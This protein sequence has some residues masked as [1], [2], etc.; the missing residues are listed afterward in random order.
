MA[1]GKWWA[2]W[3]ALVC[4]A[5]MAGA[6]L[7]EEPPP[8]SELVVMDVAVTESAPDYVEVTG[9]EGTL[10]CLLMSEG[11]NDTLFLTISAG[12][13]EI[14][15]DDFIVLGQDPALGM[16]WSGQMN[17]QAIEGGLVVGVDLAE[18]A[19]IKL[20]AGDVEEPDLLVSLPSTPEAA[21]ALVRLWI[22]GSFGVD[23]GEGG[24]LGDPDFWWIWYCGCRWGSGNMSL[25]PNTWCPPFTPRTCPPTTGNCYWFAVWGGVVPDWANTGA[26]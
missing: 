7:G 13:Y 20:L 23:P 12:E 16:H 2:K 6:V 19:T 1:N 10:T 25:C 17:G 14:V 26:E 9:D 11:G 4:V 3:L 18:G 21:Q 15:I 5:G 22:R 8:G 24:G